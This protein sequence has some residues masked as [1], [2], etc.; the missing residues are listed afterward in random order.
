MLFFFLAKKA[1]FL[2]LGLL[3]SRTGLRGFPNYQMTDY[4]NFA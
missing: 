4:R 2:I 1:K 3:S